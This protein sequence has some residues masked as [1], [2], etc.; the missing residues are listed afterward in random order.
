MKEVSVFQAHENY[1]LAL[2]FSKEG[3]TLVSGGM[4]KM[5]NFWSVPAW[6]RTNPITGHVQSIN[7]LDL[8]PDGA[9][10]LSGSTDAS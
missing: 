9:S 7:G 1:V 2:A 8:S 6:E 10:L 4:D 3:K 5:I